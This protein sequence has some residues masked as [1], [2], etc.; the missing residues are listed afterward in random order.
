MRKLLESTC[1]LHSLL[2][3]FP[4]LFVF[5]A[6]SQAEAPPRLFRVWATSCAHVPADIRRGRES[7]AK[8]IRQSEGLEKRAPAFDWDIM[9]DA[10]DLSAHQTP[11]GDKD[12]RELIR[13]YR[14]MTKHRREQIYNVP[15]N[16]DAPYY[17]HGPGSW[18][19]KWG[20]PLGENTTVSGVDPKRR[21]FPVEG[22]WERYRF[23]AGN[24]LFLMLAD[25]N[26]A[27]TP[28]GRGHSRERNSGGYPPGA[29]TRETFKWWKQQVLDNQDKIIVTMHHNALRDTTVG[30]GNGEGHPRYHGSSGGAEGSSYL[31]FIIEKDDP[32]DFQ[33][34][35]DAH[36]FEDFLDSFHKQHGRG[37]IDLWIAGHTHVKGPDDDWGGKTITEIK[38]GVNFLQVAALTRFH[39][40]SH[41]LSRLLTFKDKSDQI[42]ADVYLH[43]PSYKGNPVGWY[44]AASKILSLR[45]KFV[46][47]PPI[48]PMPPFP[49]ETKVFDEPYVKSSRFVPL[50][51]AAPSPDLTTRWDEVK[52]GSL[53]VEAL[54]HEDKDDRID[55]KP[56]LLAKSPSGKGTTARFD[57]TQRVRIGPINMATWTGLTV[58]AWISTSSKRAGMRV[59]SKD[60]IGQAGNFMFWYD[61]KKAWTIQVRD[62]QAKAWRVASWQSDSINNGDWHHLVG[63]VDSKNARVLLY[64]DGELKAESPWTAKTLDDS[65]KTDLVIGADSGEERFGH[66]F[67][68]MIH[69]T[70][71][72]PLALTA[73]QVKALFDGRG[74][75]ESL[76][77][78]GK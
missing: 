5:V 31:Y 62:S 33:Y 45:R 2:V 50:T 59:V 53:H 71:L 70:R 30:S 19:S 22:T 32:A 57:G 78:E 24:I 12:G 54:L 1:G 76:T 3:L 52:G 74:K 4:S 55:S 66:T 65:D 25:R 38:W 60:R 72:Y 17:D 68:G 63:I 18:F 49:E 64:V 48:R 51:K 23:L 9:I 47:P 39:G 10:G 44:A 73:E 61:Q 43:E 13:Q 34:T 77:G 58:C 29:V 26:D 8:A 56:A 21:P 11:P 27:P 40:G 69:D 37:A 46:A 36:V 35:K 75:G 20:D 41:P 67:Q 28:V 15:G 16:H 6:S 14:A 42:K 7:L